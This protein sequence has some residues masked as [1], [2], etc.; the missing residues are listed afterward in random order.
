[1]YRVHG[2]HIKLPFLGICK[3]IADIIEKMCLRTC[4]KISIR[5]ACASVQCKDISIFHGHMVW[6]ET[7]VTRVTDSHYEACRMMPK[8]DPE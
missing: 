5:L 2:L 1:M 8:S 6:I 7:S 4:V 3:L